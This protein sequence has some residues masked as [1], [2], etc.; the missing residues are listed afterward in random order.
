MSKINIM[1]KT[2]AGGSKTL[3]FFLPQKFDICQKLTFLSWWLSGSFT[4]FGVPFKNGIAS[5]IISNSIVSPVIA[6]TMIINFQSVR[7]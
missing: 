3:K 1:E 7:I 5:P 4:C 6:N 2:F